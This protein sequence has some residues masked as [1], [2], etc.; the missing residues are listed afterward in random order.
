MEKVRMLGNL[1][2]S[3]V[4]VL[5]FTPVESLMLIGICDGVADVV[6]RV[7]LQD[8]V[9]EGAIERLAEMVAAHG[10]DCVVAVVVSESGVGC[11]TRGEQLRALVSDVGSELEQRGDQI[12]EVIMVDRIAAGGRWFCVGDSATAGVLDDPASSV[13]AA[14][15]V[16]E[17]RRLFGSRS[18]LEELVTVDSVR[19]KRVALLVG[20]VELVEDVAVAVRAAVAAMHRMADGE[21]LS[22]AVLAE[23]GS[24]L[25]DM[26]VRD[27]LFNMGE[28]KEMMAAEALW[29]LLSRVLPSPFRAEALTLL[30]MSC[31]LRGD[32]SVAGIALEAVLENHPQHRMAGMLD[33]A[34]RSG[35]HPNQLRGLIADRR[36]AVSV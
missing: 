5:G 12:L 26:R 21:Q 17:G 31:Y 4:A 3:I 34:L 36:P 8:L 19:A 29:S 1:V 35:I 20:E 25:A 14:E 15:A 16:A 24:A 33:T 30:A 23:V 22:D 9:A 32:G 13:L 27:A 18:E 6:L 28:M 2:R 11:S 10:S 7:D